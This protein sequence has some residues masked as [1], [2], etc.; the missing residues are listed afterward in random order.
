MDDRGFDEQLARAVEG[1]A[2]EMEGPFDADA[3]AASAIRRRLISARGILG[4]VAASLLL[5]VAAL[6]LRP[7]GGPTPPATGSLT[8]PLSSPSQLP[9]PRPVRAVRLDT[10]A[11][12]LVYDRLTNSLWLATM[13]SGGPDFLYRVDADTHESE[14]WQLPETD[15]NGFLSEIEVADDGG[16]WIAYEYLL[17]HFDPETKTMVSHQFPIVQPEADRAGGTWISG[18]GAAGDEVWVARNGLAVLVLL[19]STMD[20]GQQL[21]LPSSFVGAVDVATTGD[22]LFALRPGRDD[23]LGNITDGGVGIFARDGQLKAFA[24]AQATRLLVI[25]GRVLA[26]GGDSTWAE[27][28]WIGPDG[29]VDL[30]EPGSNHALATAASTEAVITYELP[31]GP[32]PGLIERHEHGSTTIVVS[33]PKELV[34]TTI[35]RH[36]IRYP[37]PSVSPSPEP[38]CPPQWVGA[39]DITAMSVDASGALWYVD[40]LGQQG[41]VLWTVPAPPQ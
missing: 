12:D 9:Q 4:L 36:G 8:G 13:G 20:Q 41:A 6:Q 24:A 17:V 28:A 22:E 23:G 38:S 40:N 2:S 15:H 1:L 34:E 5:V 30:L 35:C 32:D 39:P 7:S 10:E 33:F 37:N 11:H 26:R 29:S 19:D 14:R 21:E 3:I 25:D 18:L 31:F 27:T 16:V